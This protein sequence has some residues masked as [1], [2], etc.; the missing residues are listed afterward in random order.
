MLPFRHSWLRYGKVPLSLG[1]KGSLIFTTRSRKAPVTDELLDFSCR[2]FVGPF[3][4]ARPSQTRKPTKS[5][6]AIPWRWVAHAIVIISH[7]NALFMTWL[8]SAMR[9]VATWKSYLASREASAVF[10]SESKEMTADMYR[11][12]FGLLA[13]FVF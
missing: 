11:S 8:A 9:Q 2:I 5:A 6:N 7:N 1:M 10:F 13:L 12:K 4:V 3:T